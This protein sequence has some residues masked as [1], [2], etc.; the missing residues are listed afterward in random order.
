MKK[1]V[2]NILMTRIDILSGQ[3]ENDWLY[4]KVY[5]QASQQG[6]LLYLQLK[7]LTVEYMVKP[8]ELVDLNII[9]V[10]KKNSM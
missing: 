9:G 3:A 7:K 10:A 8:L 1:C 5:G 4:K 6:L 2:K